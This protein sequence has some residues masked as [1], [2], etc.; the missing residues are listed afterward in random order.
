[1]FQVMSTVMSECESQ[2]AAQLREV[3]EEDTKYKREYDILE[4]I[5]L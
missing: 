1:M 5:R 3:V 4:I 2:W